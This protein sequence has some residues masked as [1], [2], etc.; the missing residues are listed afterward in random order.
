MAG[1]GRVGSNPTPRANSLFNRV[2]PS[3][4]VFGRCMRSIASF[5]AFSE[6]LETFSP[7][8]CAFLSSSSSILIVVI[9]FLTISITFV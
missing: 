2:P 4:A 6:I 3:V 8:S 7:N 1:N 5:M 9:L